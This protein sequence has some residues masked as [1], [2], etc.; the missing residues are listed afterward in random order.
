MRDI[1]ERNNKSRQEHKADDRKL[2]TLFADIILASLGTTHSS[3]CI[4]L[5]FVLSSALAYLKLT[6]E[7]RSHF[8]NPSTISAVTTESLTYLNAVIC[9]GLRICPPIP[10]G[11]PRISPGAHISGFYI[12]KGVRYILIYFAVSAISNYYPLG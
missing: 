1:L 6:E 3:I 5:F 4:V 7:I 10:I 2:T 11:L 12:P 8:S 9:E